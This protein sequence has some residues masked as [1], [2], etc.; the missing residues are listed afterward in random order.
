MV[1]DEELDFK[2]LFRREIVKGLFAWFHLLK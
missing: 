2:E 1:I